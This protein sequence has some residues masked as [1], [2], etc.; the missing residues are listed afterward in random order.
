MRM[1]AGKLHLVD[2][3]TLNKVHQH[4][5]Y[6]IENSGIKF[7]SEKALEILHGAGAKVNGNIAKI[8]GN[9]IET[10]LKKAPN[11]FTLCARNPEFDLELNGDKTFCSQDGCAAFTL[12]I[13]VIKET[14]CFA[15][16]YIIVASEIFYP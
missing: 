13:V 14:I 12:F 3:E 11:T 10:A 6:I 7:H 16:F 2:T 9:I 15:V 1:E 5:L 4:S 8:P